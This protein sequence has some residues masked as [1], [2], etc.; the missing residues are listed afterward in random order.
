MDRL[1][2]EIRQAFRQLRRRPLASLAVILTLALGIAAT[3]RIFSLVNAVLL[4]PLPFDHAGRLV[5]IA[6][7]RPERTEG[8]FSLPEFLDY[9]EA[10][11]SLDQL[12]AYAPWAANLTGM[13]YAKRLQGL[14]MSANAFLAFGVRPA[15]GRLLI[16]ADE[17]PGAP[18]VAVLGYDVWRSQFGSDEALVGQPLR[19]NGEP[20]V[21][22]GILPAVFPLPQRDVEVVVPLAAEQDPSREVRSSASFL[23]FVGRL[24][25]ELEARAAARELDG[26]AAGLRQ[27]FPVEYARKLGVRVSPLQDELVGE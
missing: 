17:Q 24:R 22:V 5:W 27:R 18:R 9:R 15:R 14:R 19:R 1:T 4:R 2:S 8:P 20:Y 25:P 7:V 21:V 10:T 13:G 16:P 6:S 26:I 11:R 23:R 3:T 12:V